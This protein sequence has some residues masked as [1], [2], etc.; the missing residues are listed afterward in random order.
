MRVRGTY[1]KQG[2]QVKVYILNVKTATFLPLASQ[3]L[4]A[5]LK[6]SR[7]EYRRCFSGNSSQSQRKT[8]AN[9]P[10]NTDISDGQSPQRTVLC[11]DYG[12]NQGK[13]LLYVKYLNKPNFQK[14]PHE[15][16]IN[17]IHE[18]QMR[19]KQTDKDS[20]KLKIGCSD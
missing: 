17:C 4:A 9:T 12:G 11:F 8:H 5:R 18:A 15:I 13:F 10:K 14:N 2:D 6:Y 16:R 20:W 7:E 3:R 1:S 19:Q